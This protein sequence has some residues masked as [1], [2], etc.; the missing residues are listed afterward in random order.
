[1]RPNV[2][3]GR[4]SNTRTSRRIRSAIEALESRRL[5]AAVGPDGFG[6]V[7]DAHPFEEINLVEGEARV[8]RAFSNL[9]SVLDLGPLTFNF[10]GTVFNDE[11]AF[12]FELRG[13]HFLLLP[14][15]YP[16]QQQAG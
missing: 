8:V 13:I 10:Y 12:F 1:M 7:A 16:Q 2:N 3:R 11:T 14:R 4:R 9:G 5:L 15:Q 6:Y